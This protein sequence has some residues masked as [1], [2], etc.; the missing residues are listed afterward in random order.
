MDK[1]VAGR[2]ADLLKGDRGVVSAATGLPTTPCIYRLESDPPTDKPS[3]INATD[4][5]STD[6]DQSF[7]REFESGSPG[8]AKRQAFY[9]IQRD[10]LASF[11]AGWIMRHMSRIESVAAAA[12]RCGA[13]PARLPVVYTQP[14]DRMMAPRKTGG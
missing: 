10:L 1:V 7:K 4:F 9:K 6:L 14:I 8:S 13:M 5:D 12:S 11:E 3:L 2:L